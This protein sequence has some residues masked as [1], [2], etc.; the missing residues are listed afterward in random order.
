MCRC[1]TIPPLCGIMNS[2]WES[3]YLTASAGLASSFWEEQESIWLLVLLS[4]ICRIFFAL[5]LEK[6]K[7]SLPLP[8][9][10]NSALNGGTWLLACIQETQ[11]N[12]CYVYKHCHALQLTTVNSRQYPH[13]PNH[14]PKRYTKLNAHGHIHCLWMYAIQCNVTACMLYSISPCPETHCCS[15]Y[16]L[17]STIRHLLRI[18]TWDERSTLTSTSNSV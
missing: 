9:G 17:S 16:P 6:T 10:I 14:V 12:A 18:C 2:S 7:T 11:E 3:M 13:T 15:C 8:I 1:V 5:V 4:F